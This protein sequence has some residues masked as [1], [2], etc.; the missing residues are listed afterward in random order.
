MLSADPLPSDGLSTPNPHLYY[1]LDTEL[2]WETEDGT[3]DG[4]CADIAFPNMQD[5]K[6]H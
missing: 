1:P 4:A 2:G 6:T 5:I 3:T